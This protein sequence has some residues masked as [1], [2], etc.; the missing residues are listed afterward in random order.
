MDKKLPKQSSSPS[1]RSNDIEI[2]GS[3]EASDNVLN[4]HKEN[5]QIDSNINV[6]NDEQPKLPTTTASLAESSEVANVLTSHAQST[7]YEDNRRI[8]ASRDSSLNNDDPKSL[9]DYSISAASS[10]QNWSYGKGDYDPSI[11]SIKGDSISAT[12]ADYNRKYNAQQ[13]NN[14]H[15][16][17]D[18]QYRASARLLTSPSGEESSSKLND[19]SASNI[20]YYAA[21]SSNSNYHNQPSSSKNNANELVAVQSTTNVD[22]FD[23]IEE[24]S[25]VSSCENLYQLTTEGTYIKSSNCNRIHGS[26]DAGSRYHRSRE[27]NTRGNNHNNYKKYHSKN[28]VRRQESSSNHQ[29]LDIDDLPHEITS[30]QIE[31]IILRGNGN[32]TLFGLSNSFSNEFPSALIGRVSREEFNTTM[33]RINSL[34]KEQQS[35]SAKLLLF[36]GLCC[37]CSFGFSLVWPSIALKKRSKLSLQKLLASENNRLYSKLGLNWKL[38]EQRCYSNHAFIEYVLMIEFLPKI[39]IYVPD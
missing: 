4:V 22:A 38:A 1:I 2:I 39:N 9:G 33:R 36:G 12:I 11:S 20:N 25:N 30:N 35:L 21:S 8:S 14:N 16:T 15:N 31:P 18:Y 3:N 17:D 23:I 10:K 7:S 24:S 6:S 19:D 5:N 13:I 27:L 37:C 29:A 28:R 34:M 32:L 26:K